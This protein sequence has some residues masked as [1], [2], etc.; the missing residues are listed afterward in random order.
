MKMID[1]KGYKVKRRGRCFEEE[2]EPSKP[3]NLRLDLYLEI[4]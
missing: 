2:L 4:E 1:E 3:G